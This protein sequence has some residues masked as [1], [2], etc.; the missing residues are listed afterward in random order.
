MSEANIPSY[1]CS[2]KIDEKYDPII[3]R[4]FCA[5]VGLLVVLSYEGQLREW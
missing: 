5:A 1:L 3:I 4:H 2:Q